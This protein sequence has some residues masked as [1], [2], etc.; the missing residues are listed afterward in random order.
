M[1]GLVMIGA[2]AS[3]ITAAPATGP[4]SVR[5]RCCGCGSMDCCVSESSS[6]R[7]PLPPAPAAA[8]VGKTIFS[9]LNSAALAWIIP[10]AAPCLAGSDF[11]APTPAP[12]PP[13][14]RRH[15]AL[16]I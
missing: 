13:L 4:Q 14:Y 2:Q 16:L 9:L 12:R 6:E 7:Q 1:L 15:C 8:S 11:S 5:C 3:A 10:S